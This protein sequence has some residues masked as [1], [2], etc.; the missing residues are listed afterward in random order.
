MNSLKLVAAFVQRR[1]LT[2][3]LKVR[4][5]TRP[6]SKAPPV[7]SIVVMLISLPD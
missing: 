4:C 2:W 1:P 6:S 5:I 7:A 3:G